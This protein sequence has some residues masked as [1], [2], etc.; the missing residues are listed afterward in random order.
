MLRLTGVPLGVL[1]RVIAVES[2]AP[3]L[4]AAVLASGTGFL[5]AHLFLRAQMH[6]S[7]Q[8]P[9]AAYYV[10]VLT[11]LA[12]SLG[13]ITATLPLLKRITGPETARNE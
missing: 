1:R 10:I 3:L 13:I 7:L 11:G 5:A 9:G 6:Y 8:P 4:V 12:A 2:A